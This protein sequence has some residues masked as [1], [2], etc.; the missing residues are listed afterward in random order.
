MALQAGKL[1][2]SFPEPPPPSLLFRKIIGL[3]VPR[4]ARNLVPFLPVRGS[5]ENR[6]KE[7]VET[8]IVYRCVVCSLYVAVF[9]V[10]TAASGVL[11]V[12]AAAGVRVQ[13]G[14]KSPAC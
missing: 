13:E 1:L 3:I 4:L 9:T 11:A 8:S 12:Q 10:S 6:S 14:G 2:V 7:H 5:L